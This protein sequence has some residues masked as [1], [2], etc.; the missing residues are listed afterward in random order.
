MYRVHKGCRL[1]DL[2][3]N[4]ILQ[5]AATRQGRCERRHKL[6]RG[7]SRVEASPGPQWCLCFWAGARAKAPHVEVKTPGG[8]CHLWC[9]VQQEAGLSASTE[10][11]GQFA[12]Q[13][14]RRARRVCGAF[15]WVAG[16]GHGLRLG[17]AASMWD[18]RVQ[19]PT[20]RGVPF[21]R[22]VERWDPGPC[23]RLGV[24]ASWARSMDGHGG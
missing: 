7:S 6:K 18:G 21:W 8:R 13:N 23:R 16:G 15:D 9:Q 4:T 12:R 17:C 24:V 2:P 14:A 3:C 5:C 11:V 19:Q 22:V 10:C 1:P 20:P